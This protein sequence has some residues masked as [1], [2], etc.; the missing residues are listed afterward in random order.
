MKAEGGKVKGLHN[1]EMILFVLL[2]AFAPLRETI[3]R[4]LCNARVKDEG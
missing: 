4:T 2:C 1:Q 3:I